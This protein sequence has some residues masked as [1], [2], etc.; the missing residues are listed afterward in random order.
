MKRA[1]RA[2]VA[3]LGLAS[4]WWIVEMLAAESGEVMVLTT[5]DGEGA[6]AGC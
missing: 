3:L 2:I 5:R 6:P 1:V 4:L